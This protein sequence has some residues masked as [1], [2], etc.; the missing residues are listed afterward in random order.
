MSEIQAD[1]ITENP[2]LSDWSLNSMLR[3]THIPIAIQ[4]QKLETRIDAAG[5]AQNPNTATGSDLDDLVKDRGL[6][7]LS[8]TKAIGQVAFVRTTVAS[9]DITIPLGTEVGAP[10]TD[11]VGP[12]Y[13]VTTEEVTLLTGTTSIAADVEAAEAGARGNVR[14]GVISSITGGLS[15]VDY[16]I[17]PVEFTGGADAESDDDLRQRYIATATEYGRA[18]VPT[19]KEWLEAV[20][21]AD[22]AKVVREAKVY[23][24]GAGDIEAIADISPTEENV[25]LVKDALEACVAGGVACRGMLA[26]TLKAGAN[27]GDLG[28][29]SGGQLWARARVNITA[30]D[31]LLV[32]YINQNGD[33]HAAGFV[34]PAG[35]VIGQCIEGTLEEVTDEVVSVPD[36]PTYIG[37]FEYD[38]LIGYGG[39]GSSEFSHP[40]L[41][42]LPEKVTI[43]VAVS[44]VANDTPESNLAELIEASIIAFLDDFII[45]EELQFSDLYDAARIQYIGGG[46]WGDRFYGI[47]EITSLTATDGSTTI[48]ALG[49]KIVVES[50]ARIDPGTVTPTEV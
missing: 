18:T 47:D 32:H 38:C 12:V 44:Y 11:G 31:I 37:A 39:F 20:A 6:T 43:N 42:L 17:N 9:A 26:A 1:M 16:V 40:Y 33:T 21:D 45:G 27:V 36:A 4:I 22:G 29:A 49:E 10:D 35:T 23:S 19:M 13:F 25:N 48:S 15:G 28:D 34:I 50:D 14:S 30:E 7:R 2:N 3:K 8:G 24:K 46:V 41:F 5:A